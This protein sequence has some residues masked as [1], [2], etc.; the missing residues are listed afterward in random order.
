MFPSV[1]LTLSLWSN[2]RWL[3]IW[4]KTRI[5]G[6]VT[7][8]KDVR[9]IKNCQSCLMIKDVQVQL[10]YISENVEVS[11]L[12]TIVDYGQCRSRNLPQQ[13]LRPRS[14]PRQSSGTK[15]VIE[16][17]AGLERIPKVVP[18]CL[19]SV[20]WILATTIHSYQRIT[21]KTHVSPTMIGLN[22]CQYLAP[23]LTGHFL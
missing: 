19:F 1:T 13:Q 12:T 20:R 4:F 7:K 6:C 3:F 11:S 10:S 22:C 8:K 17:P 16:R 9:V 18:I 15:G 14:D 2:S 23:L 21:P 5:Y